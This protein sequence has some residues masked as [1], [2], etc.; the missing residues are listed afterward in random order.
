MPRRVVEHSDFSGGDWG[1][2]QPWTARKNQFKAINMLVYSTGELGVRPGLQEVTPTN[3]V[4]G[5]TA[6][7]MLG[8]RGSTFYFGQGTTL[9]RGFSYRNQATIPVTGSFT[10]S[11]SN[12]YFADQGSA[13]YIMEPS[14]GIYS[15]VNNTLTQLNT[16]GGSGIVLY[17]DRLAVTTS[18]G[19]NTSNLRYNGLTAGV[20]DLTSWPA[21]N[22]IPIGDRNES[23]SNLHLQRGHLT[24]M[25]ETNGLFIISGAL[26]VSENLRRAVNTNGPIDGAVAQSC[27]TE[28]D[29]IWYVSTIAHNIPAV[30]DGTRVT[31]YED[32]IL[33]I[34][35][36]GLYNVNPI[37]ISDP[38]GVAISI[39]VN[40][41]GGTHGSTTK[42]FL[43]HHGVWTRHEL[44]AIG[45]NSHMASVINRTVFDPGISNLNP[46]TLAD[47]VSYEIHDVP[48]LVLSS[49]LANPPL[50][51][52]LLLDTDRPGYDWQG[53]TLAAFDAEMPGDDSTEQVSGSVEFPEVHLENADEFQVQGVI[54]DFRSWNTR[55]ALTNHFDIEV[56]CLRPYDNSSPITSLTSAWDEAGS[57]SSTAGTVK[58]QTFMFGEQGYGNG[59]QLRLSNIRGVAIQRIQVILETVKIR[60]I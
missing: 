7:G 31:Y 21:A 60:G 37:Q 4:A 56:D 29:L 19:G 52:T 27:V 10:G 14:R 25:K 23:P 8:T 49:T 46:L 20:S 2:R 3:N 5:T 54:V 15:V 26:G 53:T 48:A 42:L 13:F 32:Q 59:Y 57:L 6:W 34:Q 35:E 36:N 18:T 40:T 22:T 16:L 11:V 38:N 33:P 47:D 12:L 30:F 1:R 9:R 45:L 51:Y 58:R 24:I 43:F 55:G 17:G 44:P 41:A 28:N 50:F 39:G